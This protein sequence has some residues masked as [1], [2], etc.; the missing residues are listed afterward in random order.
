MLY[1]L[2]KQEDLKSC[3]KS[4]YS[5]R[6]DGEEQS[7]KQRVFSKIFKLDE[8]NQDRFAMMMP[9]PISVFKQ[10]PHAEMDILNKAVKKLWSEC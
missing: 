5:L 10:E 6:L 1:N 7:K 4:I 3:N 2:F 9:L 8:N